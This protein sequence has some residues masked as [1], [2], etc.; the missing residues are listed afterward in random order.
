MPRAAG[1]GHG[2]DELN[3][4]IVTFCNY[5]T[6]GVYVGDKFGQPRPQRRGPVKADTA[7]GGIDIVEWTTGPDDSGRT[8]AEPRWL[9]VDWTSLAPDATTTAAGDAIC[10]P[11]VP[12]PFVRVPPQP[13]GPR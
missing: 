11:Y 3:E 12:E 8:S 10:G 5:L 1:G 6:P 13:T 2:V 4:R 7:G 9:V